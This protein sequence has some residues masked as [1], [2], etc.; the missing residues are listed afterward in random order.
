MS[1]HI[2][3][4]FIRKWLDGEKI[5]MY[6]YHNGLWEDCPNPKWNENL[7][8]RVK[9]TEIILN[10]DSSAPN[11]G[12]LIICHNCK[13]ILEFTFDGRSIVSYKVLSNAL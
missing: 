7:Q 2:H 1:W 12:K 13:P 11:D 9:P 6:N 5:E 8:Y 4:K 3:D 10:I